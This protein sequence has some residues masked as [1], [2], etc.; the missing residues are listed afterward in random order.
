MST[1]IVVATRAAFWQLFEDCLA[2]CAG[3]S[4]DDYWL[5]GKPPEVYAREIR[6][7]W[8]VSVNL[9]SIN[10]GTVTWQTMCRKLGI[11]SKP[12]ASL[13]ALYNSLPTEIQ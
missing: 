10:L 2:D 5:Q 13:K 12:Q 9:N 11:S 7:R 1:P 4:P 8:Q 6:E 3:K